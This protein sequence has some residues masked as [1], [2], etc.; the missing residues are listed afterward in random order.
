MERS[1]ER[2]QQLRWCR[3]YAARLLERTDDPHMREKIAA[4]LRGERVDH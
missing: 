3:A 2:D 1:S 4:V